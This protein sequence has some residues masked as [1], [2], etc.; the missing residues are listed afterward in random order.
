[1]KIFNKVFNPVPVLPLLFR[2]IVGLNFDQL[3]ALPYGTFRTLLFGNSTP[4]MY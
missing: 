4:L 2:A 1:M 3:W